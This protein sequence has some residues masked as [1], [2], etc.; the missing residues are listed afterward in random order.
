[1]SNKKTRKKSVL[2]PRPQYGTNTA[3]HAIMLDRSYKDG[4]R[5]SVLGWIHSDQ[6]VRYT[7]Q[8][9][10]VL[11]IRFGGPQGSV[12]R[13]NLFAAEVIA[14]VRE[15]Y[16]STHDYADDVRLY[17]HGDQSY[18]STLLSRKSTSAEELGILYKPR[19]TLF[20]IYFLSIG[21]KSRL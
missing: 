7:C 14:I 17:V 21:A 8:V 13:S 18:C 19:Y 3:D 4:V 6:S 2:S 1:M 10:A 11:T 9:S 12:L 15:H 16:F 20:Q 5:G